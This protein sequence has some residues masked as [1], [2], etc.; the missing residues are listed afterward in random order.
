VSGN[1]CVPGI[2]FSNDPL[3]QG[4][5]FSYLDTQLKRLG[6]PNF[7]QLP[8][9]APKCPFHLFQQDGHM[10]MQNPKGRANYEP[11]SLGAE[12]GPRENPEIGFRSYP[13]ELTGEK[14]RARAESF[15]DHYSQA[16]QFYLSQTNIEQNHIADA[17]IFE[18]SKVNK[19]AIRERVVSHLLNIDKS[20][21]TNVFNGLRLKTMPKAIAT[22]KP[23]NQNLKKSRFLSIIENG[24][25]SFAGRKIGVL[26]TDNADA[27]IFN[28]LQKWVKKSKATLEVI[29][30]HIG[31]VTLNDKT[32]V[33]AG[34][35]IKGAPSVLYD[36][37]VILVSDKETKLLM[38]EPSV[39]DFIADA[40]AH[41]KFI[42]YVAE[43]QPL[44]QKA[45]IFQE[46][47]EGCV[48]LDK[49]ASLEEF[50]KKC[51]ALRFWQREEAMA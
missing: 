23:V 35:N 9:N 42:A 28:D 19:L 39:R 47:D 14:I 49:K 46:L 36:A 50:L 27:K 29:A 13:E 41:L 17:I 6:S 43:A 45:G 1:R 22:A 26:L 40:F 4:R 5:N 20:L 10:A 31:G 7:T 24:P 37:V 21:A 44:L 30:P 16:R 51:N 2:D 48:L 38:K 15:A 33:D 8:I 12:G 11:N 34:Q 3:L 25:N 32:W 18:L